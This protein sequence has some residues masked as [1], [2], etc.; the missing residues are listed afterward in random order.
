MLD[1][2]GEKQ[3]VSYNF[4]GKEKENKFKETTTESGN[5]INT[6]EFETEG[7][8]VIT[9]VGNQEQQSYIHTMREE[10]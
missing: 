4:E 2:A 5:C 3:S 9:R 1:E 8:S 10:T 6:T 7:K